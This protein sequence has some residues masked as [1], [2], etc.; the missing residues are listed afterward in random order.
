MF[1]GALMALEMGEWRTGYSTGLW[2]RPVCLRK[3]QG[4]LPLLLYQ[5]HTRRKDSVI[6]F[7]FSRGPER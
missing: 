5:L 7:L 6:L 1:Q 4:K 2:G 3:S